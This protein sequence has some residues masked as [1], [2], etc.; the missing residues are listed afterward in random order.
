MHTVPKLAVEFTQE[1]ISYLLSIL[2]PI[3]EKDP[4]LDEILWV[5]DL[6]YEIE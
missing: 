3:A 6:S 1:Q 2:E 5:F 4:K